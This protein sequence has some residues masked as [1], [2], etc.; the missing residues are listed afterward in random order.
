MKNKKIRDNVDFV[1]EFRWDNSSQSKIPGGRLRHRTKSICINYSC[2]FCS[3]YNGADD[4][5][6]YTRFGYEDIKQVLEK[7][8][9]V[10]NK[11]WE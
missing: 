4:G 8:K 10:G 7:T 2:F 11:Y 1:E 6:C 5:F 9:N 3:L